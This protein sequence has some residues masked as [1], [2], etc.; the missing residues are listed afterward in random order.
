MEKQ[1]LFAELD[2]L[3]VELKACKVELQKR[4]EEFNSAV[5]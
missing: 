5:Q 2:S 1:N 3:E 4:E